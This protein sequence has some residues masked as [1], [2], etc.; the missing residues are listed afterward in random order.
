MK[1]MILPLLLCLSVLGGCGQREK[2]PEE[3]INADGLVVFT[4][5]T[6]DPAKLTPLFTETTTA[7][8]VKQLSYAFTG[9]KMDIML[10]GT[11]VRTLQL[12][13]PESD[14]PEDSD[15]VIKD[16]DGDGYYDIFVYYSGHTENRGDYY[17]YDPQ[18]ENFAD[19][20]ELN[21]IGRLLEPGPDNT[22]TEKYMLGYIER[23]V[24]YKWDNGKLI[25]VKQTEVYDDSY[26]P[27]KKHTDVYSFDKNGNPVLESSE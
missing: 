23:T 18:K 11:T 14:P 9:S 15:V 26:D 4:S 7:P 16:F 3:Y 5:T 10:D 2:A 21:K 27:K 12:S 17:R 8:P 1:K 24:E 22:M 13:Y 19:A 20:D 6:E 25:P